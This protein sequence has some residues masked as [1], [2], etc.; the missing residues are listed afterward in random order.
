MTMGY[1][2]GASDYLTKPVDRDRLVSV[3][4]R[5]RR[6]LPVLVVD[7]DAEARRLLRR[8]LEYEGYAV[9]EAETGREALAHLRDTT[10]SV[11]LLDLMMPEMDGFDFA[12]EFRDHHE[13]RDIPI[14]VITAMDLSREDRARLTGRVERILQKGLHERDQLLAEVRDLVAAGVSRRRSRAN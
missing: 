6:D 14:V 11:V 12:T 5:Y 13:W 9:V 1:A 2:L 7:D 10:P 4:G 3:V 8:M